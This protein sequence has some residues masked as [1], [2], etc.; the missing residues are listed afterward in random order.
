MKFLLAISIL[1]AAAPAE[2]AGQATALRCESK[3]TPFGIDQAA[4]ALSWQLQ[5]PRR[6]AR[7]TAWQVLAASTPELLG[8]NRGDLWDSGKVDSA[9]STAARQ[10]PCRRHCCARISR[11][12]RKSP[13]PV[14]G[15]AAS[16][17]TSFM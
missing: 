13:T 15:S 12:P 8:E 14:C 9:P 6:G 16:A 1:L 3:V 11:S 4:P 17:I 10:K 7:Q 5:D 2:A